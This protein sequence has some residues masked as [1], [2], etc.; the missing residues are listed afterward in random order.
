MN[1]TFPLR[2][3]IKD[4]KVIHHSLFSPKYR[5][6]DCKIEHERLD[7]IVDEIVKNIKDSVLPKNKHTMTLGI[8]TEPTVLLMPYHIVECGLE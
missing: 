4:K 7:F 1:F 5:N 8:Y 2:Y 6:I 3:E